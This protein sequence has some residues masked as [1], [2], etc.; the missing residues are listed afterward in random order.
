MQ[1]LLV[2]GGTRDGGG[3][4]TVF[5][6]LKQWKNSEEEEEK[7]STQT[8][9]LES[10]Q[11]MCN[12][13]DGTWFTFLLAPTI[14]VQCSGWHCVS[15]GAFLIWIHHV[16]MFDVKNESTDHGVLSK[17]EREREGHNKISS[18]YLRHR[19]EVSIVQPLG[20]LHSKNSILVHLQKSKKVVAFSAIAKARDLRSSTSAG[21]GDGDGEQVREKPIPVGARCSF[22]P[23]SPSSPSSVA[24]V[25]CDGCACDESFWCSFGFW[26]CSWGYW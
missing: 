2:D 20:F 4:P 14:N 17:R 21:E 5:C 6:H 12:A 25:T 22:S 7:A 18:K 11:W 15:Y 3:Q 26:V 8:P 24:A 10:S 13:E 16:Q 1:P 9:M 23:L 19:L